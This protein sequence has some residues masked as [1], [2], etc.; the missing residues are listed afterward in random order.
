MA[1]LANIPGVLAEEELRT[2][3]WGKGLSTDGFF[4]L[5]LAATGS[6]DEARRRTKIRRAEYIKLGLEPS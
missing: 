5:V 4:D 1:L 6:E 3:P 2:N